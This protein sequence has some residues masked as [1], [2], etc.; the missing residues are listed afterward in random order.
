[1]YTQVIFDGLL[2]LICFTLVI[3]IFWYVYDLKQKKKLQDFSIDRAFAANAPLK[4]SKLNTRPDLPFQA[5]TNLNFDIPKLTQANTSTNTIN[6]TEKQINTGST[7]K[8]SHGNQLMPPTNLNKIKTANEPIPAN[9]ILLTNIKSQSSV[10]ENDETNQRAA[11][12]K[13]RKGPFS[14]LKKIFHKKEIDKSSSPLPLRSRGINS[15]VDLKSQ[16]HSAIGKDTSILPM[17]L[18]TH[19]HP[20]SNMMMMTHNKPKQSGKDLKHQ[21]TSELSLATSHSSYESSNVKS[22]YS[23]T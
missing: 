21:Q 22:K 2:F 12:A 11:N 17:P 5:S 8:S 6:E 20:D 15:P 7:L 19:L 10:I 23:E 18:T 4:K 3:A 13:N 1:L 16:N 9:N 14:A